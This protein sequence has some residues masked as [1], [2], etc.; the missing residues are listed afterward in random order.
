M[1]IF[2]LA[3]GGC[4]DLKLRT[5][6]HPH[7]YFVINIT[8]VVAKCLW[9]RVGEKLQ[10]QVAHSSSKML[11]SMQSYS[12]KYVIFS[13][14]GKECSVP[15]RSGQWGPGV[16]RWDSGH[17]TWEA[18]TVLIPVLPPTHLP[19]PLSEPLRFT[20]HPHCSPSPGLKEMPMSSTHLEESLTLRRCKESKGMIFSQGTNLV[21]FK[22]EIID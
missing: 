17:I 5:L 13:E 9:G 3:W 22:D 14:A 15:L 16:R 8:S 12:W 6:W 21:L 11:S 1:C 7:A 2:H 19:P 20:A 18:E 10:N 4:W